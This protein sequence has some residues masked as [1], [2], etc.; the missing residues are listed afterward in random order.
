M[1]PRII[2]YCWFG[3]KE[4]PDAVKNCIKTWK[5]ILSDYEIKE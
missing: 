5:E 3:N 1:I 4:K 2:H